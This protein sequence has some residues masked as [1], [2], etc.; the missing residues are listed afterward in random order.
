[1]NRALIQVQ[2]QLANN[3]EFEGE[4]YVDMYFDQALARFR[5]CLSRF[6][7]NKY[8]NDDFHLNTDFYAVFL[9]YFAN[10]I[11][12]NIGRSEVCNALY[13]L[14]K[15]L[16]SVEAYYEVELPDYFRL[17]HPLGTVLG[18]AQYSNYFSVSQNCTVGNNKGIYPKIGEHVSMLM[19]SSILGDSTIG[20]NCIVS[21]NCSIIDQNIPD[22]SI[23]FGKSP[24]L[25]I[26]NNKTTRF[27]DKWL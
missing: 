2:K 3:F 8:L 19:N 14:N 12:R 4:E 27:K 22:N 11:Y 16:H 6:N 7:N 26:K 5:N 25:I 1:M 23:V 17:G 21:A 10:T 15:M 9:Y 13:A 24:D 18:R 20:S